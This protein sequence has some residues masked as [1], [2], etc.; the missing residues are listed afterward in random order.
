MIKKLFLFLCMI[1][2]VWLK[3]ALILRRYMLKFWGMNCHNLYN[4]LS[5]GSGN[6]IHIHIIWQNVN[7][8]LNLAEGIIVVLYTVV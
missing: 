5:N 6:H 7:N 8:W 3:N 4:L 2:V 1:V